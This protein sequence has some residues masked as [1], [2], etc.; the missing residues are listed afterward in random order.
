MTRKPFTTLPHSGSVRRPDWQ[1]AKD[2]ADFREPDNAGIAEADLARVAAPWAWTSDR[3]PCP[4]SP[5]ASW[6]S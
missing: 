3:R 6:P 1:Q 4:R 2:Q 5:S